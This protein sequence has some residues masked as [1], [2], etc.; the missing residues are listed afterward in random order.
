MP[1]PEGYLPRKGDELLIRVTV[2]NDY[3]KND[4]SLV[5][6]TV[7]GAPH[8]QFFAYLDKVHSIYA[9]KWSEGDRVQNSEGWGEVVA[10]HDDQVWVKLL[11]GN[12][13]FAMAGLMITADA[14]DL[15]P[16]VDTE[17]LAIETMTEAELLAGLE[18]LAPP[19]EAPCN[20]QLGSQSFVGDPILARDEA[21][22]R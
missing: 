9:R 11:H 3:G 2:R 8:H 21:A 20:G 12:K 1:L 22:N 4:G 7:T 5:S 19:P 13:E 18:G 15:D 6:V 16:Y 10:V 14:N 17:E